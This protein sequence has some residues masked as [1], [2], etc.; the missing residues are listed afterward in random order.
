MTEP[1]QNQLPLKLDHIQDENLPALMYLIEHEGLGSVLA[2]KILS[3]L[4]DSQTWRLTITGDIVKTVN[5]IEARDG[6][7]SYT[8]ER[9]AG[10]VGARTITHEDGTSDIVISDFVFFAKLAEEDCGPEQVIGYALSTA[11]HLALH[12]AGHALL[13]NRGEGSETYQDLPTLPPTPYA[14]RKHLANHIEDHRIEQYTKRH[15]PSPFSQTDHF[16]D[17]LAHFRAELNESVANWQADPESAIV[18]TMTAAND[19]IRAMVYLSAEL[20]IEND[21]AL[22][23]A[24]PPEG[25]NEYIE[26]D[27]NEWSLTLHRL[28]AAAEPMHPKEISAV[29]SDLCVL[30]DSWLR[31]NGVHYDMSDQRDSL[32]WTKVQ[33]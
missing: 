21:E 4:P 28:K 29:L 7:N 1:G 23:P 24:D 19:L 25:W 18:R 32:Y 26:A 15:A 2:T 14:W 9:G 31:S 10:H 20:G 30:A 16:A 11:A 8:T 27:W 22:R 5:A 12:E 13:R 33:Y 17:S 3:L 6:E